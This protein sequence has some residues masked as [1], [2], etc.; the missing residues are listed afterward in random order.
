M[1]RES[2][3]DLRKRL[4]MMKKE[5]EEVETSLNAYEERQIN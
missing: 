3:N 1:V 2:L 5:K 4:E